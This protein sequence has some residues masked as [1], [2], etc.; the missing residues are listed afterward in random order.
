MN[1]LYSQRM[2]LKQLIIYTS[3][4]IL[5]SAEIWKDVSAFIM[6]WEILKLKKKWES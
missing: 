1:F 4:N 3:S 6:H 2:L 5:R